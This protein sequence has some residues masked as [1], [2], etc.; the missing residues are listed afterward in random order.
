MKLSRERI[1]LFCDQQDDGLTMDAITGGT[2]RFARG[3]DMQIEFASAITVDEVTS[4]L[5]V[6]NYSIVT[7]TVKERDDR[8]GAN[9]MEKSIGLV[10]LNL[11]LT[12]EQWDAGT[13]QHGIITFSAAETRLELG[14][15]NEKT[16]YWSLVVTTSTGTTLTIGDGEV[17]LY[18]NGRSGEIAL[19]PLGSS[20]VPIGQTYSGAGA[21][22]LNGLTVGR[23][24]SWE[25]SA[26]DTNLVNGTETM[27][28]TGYF[29]AQGT[30]VTLNGTV[31]ALITALVRWPRIYIAEEIEAKLAG[32][33]KIVSEPGVLHG[34]LS[35][36]NE[37]VAS[38]N[39]GK[40]FLR[41]WGVSTEGEP[42]DHIKDLT[43]P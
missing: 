41:L 18:S 11:T 20:L 22:V 16:F 31:S 21:Y 29:Q 30:S 33:L 37:D 17:T 40:Q 4:L 24:Y 6:S 43:I 3:D 27:T 13:H 42:I 9:L 5:D 35:K 2:P 34:A 25:K 32:L 23:I 10:D 8:G 7:F 36:V 14:G 15:A 12:Q 38:P 19:P 28:S 39:F 1:R 26:N